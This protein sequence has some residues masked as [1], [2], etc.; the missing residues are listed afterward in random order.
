MNI[1]ESRIIKF[2]KMFSFL[3]LAGTQTH[4]GMQ[5]GH[6]TGNG[7]HQLSKY[8]HSLNLEAVSLCA[9]Y[10]LSPSSFY[11]DY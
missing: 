8:S 7:T 9:T 1:Y 11:V 4:T 10:Y 2:S 5:H 6:C 3:F